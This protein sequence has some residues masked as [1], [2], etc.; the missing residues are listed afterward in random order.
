M[1]VVIKATSVNFATVNDL[2]VLEPKIGMKDRDLWA[3]FYRIDIWQQQL[4]QQWF[5]PLHGLWS[6]VFANGL[7][8]KL[9]E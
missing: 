4:K 8:H 9:F 5:I 6:K 7:L 1:K 3:Q 2:D